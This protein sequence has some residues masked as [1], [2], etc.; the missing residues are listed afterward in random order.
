M[1]FIVLLL[2]LFAIQSCTETKAQQRN[3]PQV[4]EEFPTLIG[5]TPANP[6]DWPASVYAHMEIGRA[7]V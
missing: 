6:A 4:P 2:S 7:H 1:R 3:T 5:G